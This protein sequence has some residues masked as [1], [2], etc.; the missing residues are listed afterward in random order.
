MRAGAGARP[1]T[2]SG[3]GEEYVGGRWGLPLQSTT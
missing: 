1:Y 3:S 2:R